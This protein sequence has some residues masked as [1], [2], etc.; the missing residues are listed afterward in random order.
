MPRIIVKCRYYQSEKT[1]K[2]IGGLLQYIATREGVAKLSDAQKSKSATEKQKECIDQFVNAYKSIVN[3]PEYSAFEKSNTRGDASEL[4][5][6][7]IEMHPE[8][9]SGKTYLDYIATRPRVE[10]IGG[11]HGLFSDE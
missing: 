8:L 2:S 3:M 7:V 9:L 11:S 6:A 1:R 10:R 4:I 5:A